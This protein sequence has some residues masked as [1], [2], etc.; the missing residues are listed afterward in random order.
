MRPYFENIQH[1]NRTGGV[2]QVKALSLSPNTAKTNKQTKNTTGTIPHCD[3]SP[4]ASPLDVI[5]VT[6]SVLWTFHLS[7]KLNSTV[8]FSKCCFWLES[9]SIL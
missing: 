5:A 7:D 4:P 9:K 8:L 2:A 6:D 3:L 1:K